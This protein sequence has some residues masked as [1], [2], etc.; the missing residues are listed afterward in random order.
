M[1]TATIK[2]RKNPAAVT[3]IRT[4]DD[5]AATHP[6]TARNLAANGWNATG[7]VAPLREGARGVM[8]YR[9]ATTGEWVEIVRV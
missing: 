2:G 1:Q 9:A 5:L 8:V 6:N 7:Y 3:M 4:L